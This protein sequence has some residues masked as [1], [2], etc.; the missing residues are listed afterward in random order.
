MTHEIH[1]APQH[2][3]GRHRHTYETIF[4]HPVAHN[5]EWH[6]VQS[7]LSSEADVVE[8]PNGTLHVTRY[9]K[10]MVLHAPNRKKEVSVDDV[11]EIRRF[12]EGPSETTDTSS[13]K[14]CDHVLVVIDHLEAKIYRTELR[15]SV[16]LK[17]V[18]YDPYG[19]GRHLH[20]AHEWT[21]GKRQ[22]EKKSFYDAIAA[23]LQGAEYILVVGSGTGR[24]CA[25]DQLLAELSAHYPGVAGK[26][27]GAVEVD[28]G[29][30]TENQLLAKAREIYAEYQPEPVSATNGS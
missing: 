30:T 7:L 2:L 24:S 9:G 16:P 20:S 22:P 29:H 28:S 13:A 12:L 4:R 3:N 5:L 8:G 21:N 19:H 27:I 14:P 25:M 10:C 23:A 18:T 17:L 11:L 1:T 15:G 6:D 26:I